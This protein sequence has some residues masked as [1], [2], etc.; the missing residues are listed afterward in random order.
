[1]DL[2]CALLM[3]FSTAF[4]IMELAENWDVKASKEGD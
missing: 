2:I 4:F 3:A 1:M